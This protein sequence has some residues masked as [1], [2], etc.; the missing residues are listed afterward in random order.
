MRQKITEG[1]KQCEKKM[2]GIPENYRMHTRI[3]G[4]SQKQE[5]KCVGETIVK[6]IINKN[7]PELRITGIDIQEA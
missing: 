1:E 6:E 4:V 7:F 2:N 3:I 5:G